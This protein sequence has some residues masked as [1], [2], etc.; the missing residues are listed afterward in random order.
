[1]LSR[2]CAGTHKRSGQSVNEIGFRTACTTSETTH[3][4]SG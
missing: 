1:M 4:W 3:S 2:V